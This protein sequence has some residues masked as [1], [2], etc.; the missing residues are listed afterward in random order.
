MQDT[1][2][3]ALLEIERRT[4]HVA[5]KI[6]QA[7]AAFLSTEADAVEAMTHAEALA[8]QQ[9]RGY[10][11]SL[12]E[13]ERYAMAWRDLVPEDA[14][15]RARLAADLAERH[16]F[17]PEDVPAVAAALHLDDPAVRGAYEALFGEPLERR[18]AA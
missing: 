17:R 11:P 2:A 10:R 7:L 6:R 12:W 5:I 14:A 8:E 15:G 3:I 4:A 9:E 1:Q 13:I 16:A 18:F